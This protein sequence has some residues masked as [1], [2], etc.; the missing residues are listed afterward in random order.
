MYGRSTYDPPML[1]T[2]I[3]G[4]VLTLTL[5]RPEKRNA[6]SI[7]L[8]RELAA[9]LRSAAS[10]EAVRCTVLTGAGSAFCA[11]MDVAQFGGDADRAS[12]AAGVGSAEGCS[13]RCIASC[14]GA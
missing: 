4:G 14:C 2:E 5:D 7:E 3:S 1:R 8:R 10:D 13:R 11:G 6:L 9:A 12:S